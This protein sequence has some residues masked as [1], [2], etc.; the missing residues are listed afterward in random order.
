MD[1]AANALIALGT[2]TVTY[3]GV[4]GAA[5][6]AAAAGAAVSGL[7]VAGW[8]GGVFVASAALGYFGYSYYACWRQRMT[9]PEAVFDITDRLSY[10]LGR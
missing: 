6:D 7:T 4:A 5:A 10:D 2:A 9:S 3:V 8:I 1:E